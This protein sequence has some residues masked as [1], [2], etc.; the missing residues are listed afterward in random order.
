[1]QYVVSDER[2]ASFTSLIIDFEAGSGMTT[3]QAVI[4]CDL[5]IATF[6]RKDEL[7]ISI[8]EP[9]GEWDLMVKIEFDRSN[10][11]DCLEMLT[12]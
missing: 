11:I 2:M 5:M 10:C 6:P 4:D 8:T 7:E 3:C 12:S 1:M 9:T